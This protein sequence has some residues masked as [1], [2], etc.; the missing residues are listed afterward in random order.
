[1]VRRAFLKVLNL[2]NP[3]VK[4][5]S[6]GHSIAQGLKRGM[7]RCPDSLVKE[8]VEQTFKL[9]TGTDG[10]EVTCT[11]PDVLEEFKR[12]ATKM[13]AGFKLRDREIPTVNA[14]ASF[15]TKRAD[16]GRRAAL[17]QALGEHEFEVFTK[18]S[19]GGS[20][21]AI[22]NA[23]PKTLRRDFPF[24]PKG[25]DTNSQYNHGE[26]WERIFAHA[27]KESTDSSL[28]GLKEPLKVRVIT[29]Q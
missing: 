25:W 8:K 11:P 27:M 13:V 7:P 17:A 18:K 12:Y 1:L 10:G 29:K 24:T 15:D 28:Q 23:R 20:A 26:T 19:R 21:I 5:I 4:D 3:T 2:N 9:L 6:I 14:T 16:G 22:P